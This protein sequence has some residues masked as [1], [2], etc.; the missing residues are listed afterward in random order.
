MAATLELFQAG[1]SPRARGEQ[2]AGTYVGRAAPGPP[3]T[4]GDQLTRAFT[5]FTNRGP[6][7]RARGAALDA[8]TRGEHLALYLTA[9]SLL[10]PSLHARGAVDPPGRAAQGPGTIPARGEQ[11]LVNLGPAW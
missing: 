1:P 3:R 11:H 9:G 5:T 10:G 7:P 4:R 2:A 6:S 8:P